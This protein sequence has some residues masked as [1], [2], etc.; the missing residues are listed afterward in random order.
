MNTLSNQFPVESQHRLGIILHTRILNCSMNCRSFD[1]LLTSLALLRRNF[2][3]AAT[4]TTRTRGVRTAVM[5][6]GINAVH[7]MS[8]P[9]DIT[10]YSRVGL[11]VAP[12]I[13]V[14]SKRGISCCHICSTRVPTIL[15]WAVHIFACQR[16]KSS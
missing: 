8:H 12:V 6:S 1:S 16:L 14:S 2:S 3:S 13:R 7:R 11:Q 15:H 9:D 5:V 4:T 10:F